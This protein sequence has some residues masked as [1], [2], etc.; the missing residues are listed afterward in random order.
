[1]KRQTQC[2]LVFISLLTL[3]SNLFAQRS[4]QTD[5]YQ[6]RAWCGNVIVP[7]TFRSTAVHS[8]KI[9]V[10]EVTADVSIV[11]QA[12]TTVL[13]VS[14]KNITGRNETAEL[15]IP[16]PNGAVVRS[17]T[18][19]GDS[20]KQNFEI[21]TK[22]QAKA[23]FDSIVAKLK[24]PALA[25]FAGYNLI[26]TSVFPV[27]AHGEQKV[28]IIYEHL[29]TADGNRIDY[30]LPRSGSVVYDTPWQV[31][32]KIQSK[33]KI[34][35]VYS[36]SHPIKTGPVNRKK[37]TTELVESAARNP[38]PFR[39]SYL[40]GDG[41]MSA[42]M[43]AY[44][45]SSGN[46]GYFLLL[47]GL[48]TTDRK[49]EK[50]EREIT[51]VIDRSGS[52]QGE[53]IEQA[54]EA[55]LQVVA[56]LEYGE[57]FNI[58]VYSEEAESFSTKP[59]VKTKETEKEAR[60]FIDSIIARGGTNLHD[61][62]VASLKP[63]PTC[64]QLPIVLFLTDGLPTVGEVRESAI[65]DVAQ[66]QNPHER[67]IFSFGVGYDVNT[68]LLDKISTLTR[69]FATFVTP[70]EDVEAKV[71]RVFR[72]LDGPALANP[73]L[74]VL[75]ARGE[76]AP[77]RISELLPGTIKDL[78]DGD[79]LVLLGRYRGKKPLNFQVSGYQ[80][81]KKINYNFSF[82]LPKEAKVK[83]SF[84]ARLWA[85]RKI[86]QLIDAIRDLGA[87]EHVSTESTQSR[88]KELT[89]EIVRLS[90]EFGILT[91]YTSFLAHEGVD[92]SDEDNIVKKAQQVLNERAISCRGG[93][94]SFNQEK[95]NPMQRAQS[96]LNVSNGY[97]N[98]E[99]DRVSITNVQQCN[100]GAYYRRNGRWLSQEN[101]K[102]KKEIEAD[103]TIK[104]GSPE[105]MEL[106]WK[107]LSESRNAELAL[108]GDILLTVDGENVLIEAEKAP[109][110]NK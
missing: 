77:R 65:R 12:A 29:L 43:F 2:A 38:G 62:L 90:Q 88:V 96:Y 79:Q 71:A 47:A 81:K 74:E 16:L 89:D 36:P 26:R 22:Q 46:G 49:I 7:Q 68:P 104:I 66:N 14:L 61:A 82:N 13:E 98:E 41:T 55:A 5:D 10:S 23:T 17:M 95:N 78:Y 27:A 37:V 19:Q 56:G 18:F 33:Q 100:V 92:L 34:S 3:S 25:E 105:Y 53:K 110:S 1:M 84:V 6:P 103:R 93:V 20:E 94:G 101:V 39:L 76:V 75:N 32:L 73:T 42:S 109:D 9:H 52:M 45:D 91:E 28:Q 50:V 58:I 80:G 31:K 21:L 97:W 51:L 85:S 70:Q 24:D 102:Q 107:L 67:R 59:V 64:G 72:G 44:P 108:D 4:V 69:G 60:E 87:E 11:E 63:E 99:M 57:S 15:L 35:A 48:G 8:N 40:V 54:K 106:V 30:E 86:G 83:N